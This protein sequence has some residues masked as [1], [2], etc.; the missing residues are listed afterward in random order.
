MDGWQR[1]CKPGD[2]DCIFMQVYDLAKLNR[3]QS[4]HKPPWKEITA[5]EVALRAHD[6]IYRKSQ[7]ERV[8]SA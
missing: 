1:T 7:A 8:K 3:T 2:E 4:V 5:F 6:L